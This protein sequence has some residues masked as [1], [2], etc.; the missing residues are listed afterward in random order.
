M[1]SPAILPPGL[2]GLYLCID[3]IYHLKSLCL[4]PHYC[5]AHRQAI[6][7]TIFFMLL[8]WFCP[9]YIVQYA[10]VPYNAGIRLFRG[11]NSQ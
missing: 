4:P 8:K 10:V 5:F 9:R 11:Y 3:T 1:S 2:A 6:Q 7:G